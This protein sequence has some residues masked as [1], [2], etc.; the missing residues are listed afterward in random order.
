MTDSEFKADMQRIDRDIDATRMEELMK[1]AVDKDVAAFSDGGIGSRVLDPDSLL[2]V[3]A[4]AVA[5]HDTSND[6][7][8]GQHFVVLSSETYSYVSAGEGLRVPCPE[9]YVVREH[10]GLCKEYLKREHALPVRSLAVVVYTR[11]AYCADPDVMADPSRVEG[12]PECTHVIVSVLAG[13][14]NGSVVSADRF[15]A[16]FAGGNKDYDAMSLGEL[17]ALAAEVK[18]HNKKFCVVAD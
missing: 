8:K 17:R 15:V 10:R 5:Q 2:D 18:A 16:N 7:T 12:L 11:E 1:F 9:E 4:T 13:S 6:R 3:L 14:D